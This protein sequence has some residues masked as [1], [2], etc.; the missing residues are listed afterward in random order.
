MLH[1]QCCKGYHAGYAAAAMPHL[2]CC[3]CSAA[4]AMLQVLCCKGYAAGA[5]ATQ[6]KKLDIHCCS[7]LK[8]WSADNA[9]A[10]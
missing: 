4:R 1:A 3:A 9:V 2:A 10:F 8:K 6:I 7:T 5:M